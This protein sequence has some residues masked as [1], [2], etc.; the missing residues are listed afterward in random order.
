MS[1]SFGSCSVVGPSRLKAKKLRNPFLM[2][3][4]NESLRTDN[5]ANGVS[6]SIV[7]EASFWVFSFWCVDIA[8]FH[9][10]ISQMDWETLKSN[11]IDGKFAND[12]LYSNDLDL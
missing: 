2:K 12:A 11:L 8:S 7:C 6:L 3:I 4:A 10:K 9:Q 5:Y 1:E